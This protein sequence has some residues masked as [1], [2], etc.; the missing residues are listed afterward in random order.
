[1]PERQ[2]HHPDNE[3]ID[4]MSKAPSQ[5]SSSG[6]K[7]A[8]EVGKRAE[9][10]EIDGATVEHLAHNGRTSPHPPT[11]EARRHGDHVVYDVGTQPSL[12]G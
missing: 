3:L 4:E 7:L 11:P 10:N 12:H 2:S 9:Q 6:G 8:Q 5:Q 1:M